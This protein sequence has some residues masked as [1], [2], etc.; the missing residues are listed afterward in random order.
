MRRIGPSFVCS[1][2][3]ARECGQPLESGK[4]KEIDSPLEHPERNAAMLTT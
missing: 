3:G 4:Y 2:D 1:E